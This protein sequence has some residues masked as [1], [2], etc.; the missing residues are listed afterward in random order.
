M[1]LISP[2]TEHGLVQIVLASSLT[3]NTW[4]YIVLHCW[5]FGVEAGSTPGD[6]IRLKAA[7]NKVGK[8][9]TA[10]QFRGVRSLFSLNYQ[11]HRNT[12]E[13]L[14]GN[15]IYTSLSSPTFVMNNF[16]FR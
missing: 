9:S 5:T 3:A 15:N 10:Q 16:L 6:R 14:I 1:S 4:V 7:Q 13:R 11:E 2:R 8:V 12:S